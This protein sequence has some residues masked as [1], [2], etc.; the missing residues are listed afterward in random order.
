M[1][2]SQAERVVG[3]FGGPIK[4]AADTEHPYHRIYGWLQAREIPQK[5]HQPL[6][7]DAARLTAAGTPV[8]LH[9]YDY[10]AHLHRPVVAP[11]STSQLAGHQENHVG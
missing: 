10:V 1:Q 11:V 8:D 9:P 6:L 4:M 2:Q 5:W 7:D 3:K